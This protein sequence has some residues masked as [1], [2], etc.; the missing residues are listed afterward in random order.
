MAKDERSAQ[1]SAEPR[2]AVMS[3]GDHLEELRARVI[4]GLLAV[5]AAFVLC[6]VFR[7]RLRLIVQRPHVTA[8]QALELDTALKFSS[9]FESLV[10][11]IKTCAVFALALV[12]PVILYQL[13]AFVA[14]GLFPHER[15]RGLRLAA[16]CT[17]CLAAGVCFGYFVFLPVALRYLISLSGGWAEPVLMIG[18]YLSLVFLLTAALAVAFQTPVVVFYLIRWGVMDAASLRRR[19]KGVILGAFIVGALLTPPDPVTQMMMALT[20]IVL[21]DLGGLLAAPSW[22]AFRSF[23]GFTGAILLAG[24]LALGWFHLWPVGRLTALRGEVRV[25]ES[26]VAVGDVVGVK[27]GA[28]CRTGADGTARIDLGGG[29]GAVVH[30][31]PEGRLQLHGPADL[32]L[33]AGRCLADCTAGAA[34]LTV[35]AAP[36]KALLA[37][38]RAEFAT[39]EPDALTVTTFAGTVQVSAGGQDRRV[40]AGQTATFRRGGEPADLS[41]AE[42]RWRALIDAP[43]AAP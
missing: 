29:G 9:Y 11:Q 42:T 27:R 14:P 43:A 16:A 8:M 35:R 7:D 38:G 12:S 15:R 32:S 18:S 41:D 13:W 19:R 1:D 5:A 39:P 3:L 17:V 22:P 24:G 20:L 30:L 6:W 25:G 4:I 21:Y 37:G 33:Y 28:V 34:E 10:A 40:A 31:A 2:M 23:F 26:A 36:G